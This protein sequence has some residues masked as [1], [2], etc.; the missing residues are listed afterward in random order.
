[1]EALHDLVKLGKVRYI[2][3]SSMWTYQFVMMQHCA[4]MHG[5]TKFVSMQNRY[6]L[7][8]R[9]EEREMNK[10][11][12]ETGVGII[13]W[14]PLHG[15]HLARP[16]TSSGSS[17]RAASGETDVLTEADEGVIKRVEEVAKKK[18]WPM[19]H[20]SLAWVL[21]KGA[22][23]I[24]GF[25][26]VERIDEALGVKGKSLTVEEMEYLEEPYRPKEIDSHE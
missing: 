5:W 22:I 2:G 12:R 17:E 23:P 9:E 4:E 6:S 19:T 10:Y 24:V 8:Y 16:L 21:Q 20:V 26:K 13:P 1:M 15:G 14:Q 7:L 25:S 3:A 18:G 11:C